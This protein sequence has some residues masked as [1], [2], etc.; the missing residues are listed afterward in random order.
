MR[1]G[2]L[3]CSDS[4]DTSHLNEDLDESE[5]T[6]CPMGCL[7]GA[8]TRQA[9]HCC[10]NERDPSGHGSLLKGVGAVAADEMGRTA[11]DGLQGSLE[12]AVVGL[13]E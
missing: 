1:P 7:G 11:T 9:C 13:K 10:Y 12:V 3:K 8:G 4:F 2:C 5:C 6:A